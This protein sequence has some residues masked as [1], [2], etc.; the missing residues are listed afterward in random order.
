MPDAELLADSGIADPHNYH[1]R[2]GR[3][4]PE[5]RNTGYRGRRAVAE[6]LRLTDEIREMIIARASIRALKEQARVQGT[7]FLRDVALELVKDG[8]T[9]LQ[10]V[11]RVTFVA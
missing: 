7:R 6:V 1:F 3:G 10:E 2:A 11:N 4:C 9:T 8:H 5:C